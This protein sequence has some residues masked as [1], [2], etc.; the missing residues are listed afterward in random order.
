MTCTGINNE[1]NP[2]SF[3]SQLIG[4]WCVIKSNSSE[5]WN[6]TDTS[7]SHSVS[8]SSP[9][10]GSYIQF[11]TWCDWDASADSLTLIDALCAPHA[12][13][14]SRYRYFFVG[15]NGLRISYDTAQANQV[16]LKQ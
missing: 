1:S 7:C 10:S 11:V 14:T 3:R 6:F 13:D 5:C 9:S 16:F 2:P 8:G 4:S 12:T 15:Q